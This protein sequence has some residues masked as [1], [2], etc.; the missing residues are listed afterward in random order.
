MLWLLPLLWRM[1]RT[2]RQLRH[3]VPWVKKSP[4]EY[5]H[6]HIR[7]STQ[8]ID[9]PERPQDLLT[10]LDWIGHDRMMFSPDYP[11][12]DFDDPNVVIPQTLPQTA[13]DA[14]FSENARSFYGLPK[15]G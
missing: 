4:V 11:H 9:E 3:E 5:V 15:A 12:W 8:P 13:R 10:V 6:K 7:F 2:W 1:D 14:I